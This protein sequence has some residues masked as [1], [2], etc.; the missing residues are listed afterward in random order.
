MVASTTTAFTG[1]AAAGAEELAYSF[2]VSAG[3][4]ATGCFVN[5]RTLCRASSAGNAKVFRISVNTSNSL[6][7]A[8]QVGTVTVNNNHESFIFS[9]EFA[10]RSATVIIGGG[11]ATTDME[12]NDFDNTTD[13]PAEI[14]VPDLTGA[15]FWLVSLQRNGPTQGAAGLDYGK[16]NID[17][18]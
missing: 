1:S 9:R 13:S 17:K 2:A 3:E 8:T 7:G 12:N 4:I 5:L 18:V 11:A 16:L 14:T 10:V 15:H 6:V